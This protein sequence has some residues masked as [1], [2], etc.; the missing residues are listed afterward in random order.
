MLVETEGV[1]DEVC[2]LLCME[3]GVDM[4]VTDEDASPKALELSLVEIETW[5]LE[6]AAVSTADVVKDCEV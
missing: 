6:D 2:L 3:L 5:L 1:L 4:V